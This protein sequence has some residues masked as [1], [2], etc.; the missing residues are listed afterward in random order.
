ME[1]DVVT[2]LIREAFPLQPIPEMTLHQAQLHD[3]T[4]DREIPEKEWKDVGDRDAGRTWQDITDEELISCDAALAHFDETSFVYYLPSY[5]LF[6]V[7]NCSAELLDPAASTV[8]SVV[9]SVTHRSPYTL[10]RLERFS[11]EQRAAVIA[12]LE[13]I[14]EKGN[15]HERP[16]AQKALERHWKTD[17]ASNPFFVVP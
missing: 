16:E 9:F 4:M 10:A 2:R 17:E 8:G 14:S 11:A 15:H 3:Q 13:L 1:A 5:L 6:A 7:R 12:F